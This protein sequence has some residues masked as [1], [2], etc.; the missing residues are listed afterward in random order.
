VVTITR[1]YRCRPLAER[2][3][4]HQKQEASVAV[5]RTTIKRE[6][7]PALDKVIE[8][9]DQIIAGTWAMTGPGP[10]L[11]MLLML[12]FLAF[13]V[14]GIT[15]GASP[16]VWGS[17]PTLL[18]LILVFRRRPV[19]VAVTEHQLICYRLSRMTNDPDRLLFR[20][21]LLAV[22]V[23][24]P[25]RSWPR[26]TSIRYDGPG[27]EERGLRLNVTGSWRRDLDEVL[28]ALHTRGASVAGLPPA[29][30]ASPRKIFS[31]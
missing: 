7:G 2:R 20:A 22:R 25:G 29:Q 19:F 16:G 18:S 3:I 8:P 1:P 17:L 14:T 6:V 10:W 13:G 9:G 28:A 26:Q 30:A 21:P 15:T 12:P 31:R 23:T 27:A 5:R 4:R 24:C 11:D